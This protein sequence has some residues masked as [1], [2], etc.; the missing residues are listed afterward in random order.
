MV[1]I[2]IREEYSIFDTID[3]IGTFVDLNMADFP[4]NLT[5]VCQYVCTYNVYIHICCMYTHHANTHTHIYISTNRKIM[6]FEESLCYRC[7]KKKEQNI[8]KTTR[9]TISRLEFSNLLS[10]IG[11]LRRVSYTRL[12]SNCK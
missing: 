8:S 2:R 4:P 10:S 5:L 3:Y 6:T 9:P 11:S 1:F 7:L 12:K